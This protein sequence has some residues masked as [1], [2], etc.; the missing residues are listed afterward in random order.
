[1]N[2]T[3]SAELDTLNNAQGFV[4]LHPEFKKDIENF[5]DESDNLDMIVANVYAADKLREAIPNVNAKDVAGYKKNMSDKTFNLI[6]MAI[7]KCKQKKNTEILNAL[8]YKSD[9]ISRADKQVCLSRA[10]EIQAYIFKNKDYFANIKP[11]HY[12]AATLATNTYSR[13]KDVPGMTIHSKKDFG[14]ELIKSG[15]KEGRASVLNMLLMLEVCY[16]ETNPELVKAFKTIIHITILGVRYTPTDIVLIDAI[17]GKRL[18]AGSITR[19]TKKGKV[20]TFL[21]KT[22]GVVPFKTHKAGKSSYTAKAPGYTDTDFD[23]VVKRRKK[24]SFVVNM[25]RTAN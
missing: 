1:M 10:I 23:I 14:T 16:G 21:V 3:F 25:T 13:M 11:A 2:N 19:T 12:A 8:N 17:S 4:V 15:L 5:G 18:T 6:K 24:N 20:K 7:S 9:Y 22:K